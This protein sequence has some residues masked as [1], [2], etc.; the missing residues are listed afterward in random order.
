VVIDRA[1]HVVMADPA[2]GSDLCAAVVVLGRAATWAR[3]PPPGRITPYSST[4]TWTSS[5]G[6][7][8]STTC[9]LIE[10]REDD[11]RRGLARA[12]C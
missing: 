6:W 11:G 2:G 3:Q 9:P 5:P 1:V 8:R 10:A 4:S 7:A 12:T